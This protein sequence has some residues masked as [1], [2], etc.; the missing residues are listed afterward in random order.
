MRTP[1]FGGVAPPES[2]V[3][4][5]RG[6]KGTPARTHARTTAWTSSVVSGNTAAAG[7]WRK[8]VSASHSYTKSFAG[9]SKKR[10]APTAARRP[11]RR[12]SGSAGRSGPVL[13]LEPDIEADAD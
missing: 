5:P 11:R 6:V 13:F 7:G 8:C 10:T 3:P 2:P 1:P 12:E 9:E 4:A